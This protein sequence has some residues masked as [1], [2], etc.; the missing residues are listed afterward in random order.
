MIFGD[1]SHATIS[2]PA[3][4]ALVLP[5]AVLPGGVLPSSWA[6]WATSS[7]PGGAQTLGDAFIKLVKMII[8]R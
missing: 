1:R 8:A 6:C 4:S 2:A 5:A 3:A 7:L